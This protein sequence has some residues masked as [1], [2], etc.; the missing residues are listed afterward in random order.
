MS[1]APLLY[2]LTPKEWKHFRECEAL[3]DRLGRAMEC[4]IVSI[5]VGYPE[6]DSDDTK[7]ILLDALAAWREMKGH[8]CTTPDD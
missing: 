8:V 7:D 1:D 4:A 6:Y 2:I 5:E 3:C